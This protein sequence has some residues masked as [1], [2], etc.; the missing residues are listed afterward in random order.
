VLETLAQDLLERGKLDLS[1][2]FI[3]GTF[4]SAKKGAS[5][6]ER[7]SGAV[8]YETPGSGRRLWASS[9]HLHDKCFAARSPTRRTHHL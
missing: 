6:W 9:R 1:E 4:V 7:P 2:T 3:D 5:Q 8:R